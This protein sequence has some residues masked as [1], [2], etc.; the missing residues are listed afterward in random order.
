MAML[1]QASRKN[2]AQAQSGADVEGALWNTVTALQKTIVDVHVMFAPSEADGSCM[3][4]KL[5]YSTI[6]SP[7]IARRK[8]RNLRAGDIKRMCTEWLGVLVPKVRASSEHLLRAAANDTNMLARIR[9][10]L[11]KV[12]HCEGTAEV[13]AT[14]ARSDVHDEAFNK[15]TWVEAVLF[16]IDTSTVEGGV[17]TRGL[18][19]YASPLDLWSLLFSKIFT[20]LAEALLAESLRC[21]RHEVECRLDSILLAV[22]GSQSAQ[23]RGNVLL[24]NRR[25]SS[26]A[27]MAHD[28]LAAADAVVSLLMSE[29]RS[30]ADDAWCLTERD[31]KV[32]ADALRT[33][34]Y[35]LSVETA[36]GLANH[37]RVALQEIR[38]CIESAAKQMGKGYLFGGGNIAF[39]H[40]IGSLA[41][42]GLVIG[43][44]AWML[45]GRSG[46]PLQ[47]ALT[48]P[49]CST[50][51]SRGRIEEQQLEAAF[52]IADTDG[53]GVVDTEEAAEALQAISFGASAA[54][55]LDP[56][57]YQS[58]TLSEFFLFAT[59]LLEDQRPLQH[60]RFCFDE[61]LAESLTVWAER[62]LDQTAAFLREGCSEMAKLCHQPN[63]TDDLWRQA[64]GLWEMKTIDLDRDTGDGVQE[65][66]H[67]PIMVSPA[68]LCYVEGVAAEL[69]RVLSTVDF[70]EADPTEC[71]RAGEH[72]KTH[73]T[74]YGKRE[75]GKASR[76]RGTEQGT[77]GYGQY[78]RSLAAVRASADLKKEFTALCEGPESAAT[79]ACEAAQLQILLD[80][81]FLQK[82][83]V[84]REEM[85]SSM[86]RIVETL[87]DLVDPIN[88][89]IYMPHLQAAASACSAACCT[90]L[91]LIFEQQA[92]DDSEV[93]SFSMSPDGALASSSSFIALV[94]KARRFEILPLPLESVPSQHPTGLTR[95]RIAPGHQPGVSAVVDETGVSAQARG[96]EVGRQALAG[97]MDQ[98][99]SV[100]SV[101]S[102]QNVNVQSVFGAASLFLGGRNRRGDADDDRGY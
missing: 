66:V 13:L 75:A 96:M 53:D 19:E 47:S 61:L 50:Q 16:T 102:A 62:S 65:T 80:T 30:L 71:H 91:S 35:L 92:G 4:T 7:S 58:F 76:G 45:T 74:R 27:L 42:A 32:A 97:L 2:S 38:S 36:A 54:L 31:D 88:L 84:D 99:G 70:A 6:S 28:I 67:F 77:A 60:L 1:A 18:G 51:E 83:V 86:S 100:G 5:A 56:T 8:H 49:E 52:V 22:T 29:L 46:R 14:G 34:F 63:M 93:S 57:P 24:E 55:V 87:C 69:S 33:S 37:L 43:R 12:T 95:A 79:N 64:H 89:Q 98:V 72:E 20:D 73:S 39:G 40:A 9:G 10:I 78:A 90:S 41:D 101:L 17:N 59:R 11:W 21:V 81:L 26:H 94:P 82:W 44:V 85:T 15:A 48:S 25:E 68:V 3:L 23:S